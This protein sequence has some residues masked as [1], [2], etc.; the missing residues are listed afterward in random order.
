M[1]QELLKATDLPYQKPPKSILEIVDAPSTPA[2]KI[3]PNHQYLLL[4]EYVNFLTIEELSKE[5]LKLAG[6]RINPKVYGQ[7]REKYYANIKIKNIQTGAEQQILDLPDSPKIENVSWSPDNQHIAFTHT[8]DKGIALWIANVASLKAEPLTD[9]IINDVIGGTY[10]WFR[11][12]STILLKTKLPTSFDVDSLF[13]EL[14]RPIIQFNEGKASPIRTYQDLLKNAHD[15][16]LF[17]H[18][19]TTQLLILDL[20]TRTLKPFGEQG[21]INGFNISPDGNYVLTTKLQKPFSYLVP[22]NRFPFDVIIYDHVGNKIRTVAEIPLSDDVPKGFGAV[23]KGARNFMWRADAPASLYWVEAQ[24]EGDPSVQAEVRDKL[25]ILEAPFSGD[26]KAVLSFQLRFAGVTW[27]NTNLALCEEWWWSNRK[28]ITSTWNPSQQHG[29]KEVLFDRSFEDHYNDPGDFE[30]TLNEFNRYVLLEQ[31]N[32]LYLVGKGASEQGNQ[33]FIDEFDL[34]NKTKKRLW[35]SKAPYYEVPLLILD[36]EK[37]LF[38]CRRESK[39][40]VPNLFIS[41]W[42]NGENKAITNYQNPYECLKGVEKELIR[43]QRA[44]GVQMTGTLYLPSNYNAEKDGRLPVFMWAYPKEFKSKET[45]GQVTDSP[46]EFIRIGWGSPIYWVTQG[47][48][49]FDDFSVP[50]VGEGYEEPNESFIEQ[51]Q[52]S[53]QAAVDKLV[54]IGIADPARIAVGGHSYGA[55]MTVNLLV[56]TNLFKA[57]IA[58]SGAYNRTLTPFGFQSEE[59]TLW[60]AKEVYMKMSPFL[61]ADQIKAP[62]LLIHGEM[63]NNPGTFPMQSERLF[64]ALKTH[65]ATTRLVKLPYESHG[66]QAKDSILHVLWEMSMWL[67][68]FVK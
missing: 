47:F 50:I 6:I 18:F 46:F 32:Q 37:A 44:D 3:S 22:Y 21:M 40:E 59:R 38:L 1:L 53:A 55:F 61:Y 30:T 4:L 65:G 12:G 66:Y 51:L 39:E 29:K 13:Q 49:I 23:R 31:S 45:A 58:R 14:P 17:E 43:Y 8:T 28:L 68:R 11:D 33:P 64:T 27:G 19:I 2:I 26:A 41:N 62:L 56:H 16:R 42:K 60:E 15:E 35:Q 67:E 48:A 25:F 10:Q 34:V 57:G 5:E 63:D 54:E 36:I 7:S 24:D 20:N 52:L 9:A